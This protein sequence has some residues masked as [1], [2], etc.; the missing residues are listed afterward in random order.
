MGTSATGDVNKAVSRI[1]TQQRSMYLKP[2]TSY[3]IANIIKSLKTKNTM[4]VN[5]LNTKI[6]Q[7]TA[8]YIC[9]PLTTIINSCF[10][11]GVIPDRMKMAKVIPVYKN[12]NTN[13]CTNY[14][15][16]A[17][18][19]VFSKVMESA[20][21]SGLVSFLDG[22]R[23][24]T[25]H[26]NGFRKGRSTMDAIQSLLD[27]VWTAMEDGDDA[28]AIL[29]DLSKAFDCLRHDILLQKLER[30][31]IR[32]QPLAL[33][34][35]YFTNRR[36]A[37]YVDG[38]LG[39]FLPNVNGVAQGSLIGPLTFC[40]YINDLPSN[41]Q[42]HVILFADDTT[43]V[44]RD[45]TLETLDNKAAAMIHEAKTWFQQNGLTLNERKTSHIKFT[46]KRN[47]K[48]EKTSAK[49][50]G[51]TLDTRFTWKD[52]IQD[53]SPRLATSLYAVRR[54]RQL[55]GVE[56]ALTTYHAMFHSRMTYGLRLWGESAHA[57]KIGTLQKAAIRAIEQVPS[58]THCKPLFRKYKILT[59]ASVYLQSQLVRA[60]KELPNNPTRHQ[61]TS[62]CLRN[63]N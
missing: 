50:L 51:I 33:M 60:Y 34:T 57:I 41:I 56:A 19:P 46:N 4:D 11:Q 21:M 2:V 30:S 37:V 17:V 6:I 38:R 39:E 10:E 18:L 35:S 32:G 54:V 15:P 63:R 62:L 58:T 12:G 14:R 13:D 20:M 47:T 9:E 29:C 45:K 22:Q 7:S 23:I 49:L 55:V 25:S 53:L 8:N 44:N 26:Q 5:H 52:H 40:M 59:L 1:E 28:H 16:I 42:G 36:Q 27:Y 24:L 61:T 43:L 48:I 31:G 3:E